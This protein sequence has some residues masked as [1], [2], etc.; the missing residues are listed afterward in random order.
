MYKRQAVGDPGRN[1][2]VTAAAREAAMIIADD[3]QLLPV[4]I[5]LGAGVL[6]AAKA[7]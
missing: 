5:P 1:D 7:R 6:A 3:E 4:V 2:P